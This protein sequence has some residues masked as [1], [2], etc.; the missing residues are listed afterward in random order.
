[1]ANPEH[2]AILNRG[3][4][5][6]NEWRTEHTDVT[7]DLNEVNLRGANLEGADL[8]AAKFWRANFR[9]ANLRLATLSKGDFHGADFVCSDLYM[10]RL[11]SANLCET[12]FWGANLAIS[13]LR[14]ADLSRSKLANAI[15]RSA[16]LS[17]TDLSRA[18]LEGVDFNGT[19]LI[20][21]NLRGAV[22]SHTIF[23]DVDL[24]LAKGLETIEHRGPSTVGI[25]TLYRSRGKIP[26]VFLRG[27]GVPDDMIDVVRSMTRRA[28]EF[29]SCF[30]SYSSKD[31]EFAERLH[32]DLQANGVRC[33]FAPE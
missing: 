23:A 19:H 10:A 5:H 1:M 21:T 31:Q 6:W 8:G 15:L 28:I 4:K 32:A 30:I 20:G 29:N 9:W 3:V 33:W 26:E 2:L 14:G 27:C 12:D 17:D 7:P 24:S 16:D 25:D 11:V 22:T 13:S 18:I